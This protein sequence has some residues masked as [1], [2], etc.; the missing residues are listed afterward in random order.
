M[1]Y[2]L[3]VLMPCLNEARTI[4]A[5]VNAASNF[6]KLNEIDGEVLI[7]DNGSSDESVRLAKAAGARVIIVRERGYGA[8][9]IVGIHAARGKF[10]IMG[11]ADLSYDFSLLMPYLNHLRAGSDLVIGNR[12]KGGIEPG[13]MPILHRYLG[14]PV[15]SFLGRLFFRTKIRDFHCGL[16]G[17]SRESIMNLNLVTPGM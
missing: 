11:D 9:L 12:F 3:T 15:L 8:A 1:S 7:A 13:A 14:N 4:E 5:C 10:V 6:I 17:F 2:E 16:R